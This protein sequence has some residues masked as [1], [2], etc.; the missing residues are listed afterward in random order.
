MQHRAQRAPRARQ[1]E[2]A[3][4]AEEAQLLH[5]EAVHADGGGEHNL[6]HA[7]RDHDAI[8]A[9]ERV[10]E[11]AARAADGELERAAVASSWFGFDSQQCEC[12]DPTDKVR[13]LAVIERY[14][15]GG[16]AFNFCIRRLA[17]ELLGD[18]CEGDGGTS[19]LPVLPELSF[20]GDAEGLGRDEEEACW[21]KDAL[22]DFCLA[23]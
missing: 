14:P 7:S 23:V 18:F 20:A 21:S 3:Y 13:I 9:V 19:G 8:E 2:D 16:V 11:V 4:E 1:L 17:T 12:F 22:G 5:A 10:G 15:G 6:E